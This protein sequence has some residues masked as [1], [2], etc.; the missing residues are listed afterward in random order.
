LIFEGDTAGLRPGEYLNPP[1][2][3]KGFYTCKLNLTAVFLDSLM[4]KRYG[5]I[6]T[7]ILP[8]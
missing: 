2:L 1:D 3:A 6:D 5:Y 8:D 7:E 4:Q